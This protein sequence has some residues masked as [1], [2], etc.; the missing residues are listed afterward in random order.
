MALIVKKFGG[1]SVGDAARIR[2]VAR[3]VADDRKAGNDVVVIVSAMGATTDELVRLASEVSEHTHERELDMLLTAGERISMALLAMA[4][5]DCG[6]EAMSLTG[7]Q[8]GILTD[9]AHGHARITDIR[10]FRV[11]EAL[12]A[13]R[14]VIVAGV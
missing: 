8:A 7:S 14:V 4:I 9:T 6:V 5:R 12:D 10:A 2:N 3:R 11:R 13:G 1:T